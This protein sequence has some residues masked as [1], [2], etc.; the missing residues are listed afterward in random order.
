MASGLSWR[1]AR[2]FSPLPG[3][4]RRWHA[5]GLDGACLFFAADVG[6]A[7]AD[8]RF[9]EQF[10]FFDPRRPSGAITLTA[11]ER[12]QFLR[13]FRRMSEEFAS[14]ASDARDVLRARLY[15]LL[16]AAQSLVSR[17]A[18][19]GRGRSTASADGAISIDDRARVSSSASCARVRAQARCVARS[20]ECAQSPPPWPFGRRRDPSAASA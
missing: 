11:A 12:T 7:F 19:P 10:V 18:S 2:C 14:P 4:I 5:E 8:A 17:Q 3:Q 16:V 15:E 20:P 6:E 9:L 13:R 1:R